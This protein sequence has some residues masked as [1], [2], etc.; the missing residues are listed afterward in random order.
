MI[1]MLLHIKFNILIEMKNKYFS[2]L[3][4]KK[5][6]EHRISFIYDFA[7]LTSL[8]KKNHTKVR[9]SVLVYDSHFN[10]IYTV[11]AI[12]IVSH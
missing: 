3:S 10:C 6:F 12:G 8:Q 4:R 7:N 9:V 2:I 11:K 5:L 1:V